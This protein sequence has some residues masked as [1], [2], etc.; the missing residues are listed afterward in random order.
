M[1]AGMAMSAFF[2]MLPMRLLA[3]ASSSASRQCGELADGVEAGVEVLQR[4]GLQFGDGVEVRGRH[5]LVGVVAAQ[6]VEDEVVDFRGAQ[7]QRG[8]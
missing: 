5:A 1:L 6:A 7:I 2:R 4:S 3:A 8:G